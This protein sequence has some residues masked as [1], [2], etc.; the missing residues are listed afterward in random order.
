[1]H[2]TGQVP[3]VL[4][5]IDEINIWLQGSKVFTSLDTASGFSQI[6][7]HEESHKLTPF[8]T[9]LGIMP[10]APIGNVKHARNLAEENGAGRWRSLRMTY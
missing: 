9:A 4:P 1:M 7:H 2:E 3:S 8:I 10:S 5:T 6:P